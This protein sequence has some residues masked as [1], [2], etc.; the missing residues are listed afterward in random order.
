[1]PDGFDYLDAL[2]LSPEAVALAVTKPKTTPVT[3]PK[4]RQRLAGEFYLCPMAWADR[5]M[6]AVASKE[7]FII[8]LR[9]YRRWRT[10]KPEENTI[11]ASNVVLKGPG[12]S[13]EVKRRTLRKLEGA[14]LLEVVERGR[15]RAPRIRMID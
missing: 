5:A 9:L 6:L 14:G 8:A 12:F 15:G 3:A 10:R 11:T 1:M 13:R 7:Q 4:Q 2:R